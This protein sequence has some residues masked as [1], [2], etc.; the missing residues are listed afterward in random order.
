MGH[1]RKLLA[2]A[3]TAVL[4]LSLFVG[5]TVAYL[6]KES[7]NTVSNRFLPA[8]PPAPAV[9]LRESGYCV[10]VGD[11][12]YAVYVRAAVV[13]KQV[14]GDS[15]VAVSPDVFTITPGDNWFLH[16]DGFYYYSLPVTSGLTSAVYKSVSA[17][18]SQD[19]TLEVDIAAQVIQAVGTTDEPNVMTAV[20]SAWGVQP[21]D[22]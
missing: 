20:L 15:V 6:A 19:G 4:V 9:V 5:G 2:I 17:S 12:G 18:G 7:D 22:P 13:P 8:Q 16:S 21:N 11:P 14:A 10:D 1:K 3:L